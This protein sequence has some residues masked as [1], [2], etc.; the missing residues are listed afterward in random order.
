LAGDTAF[1]QAGL[2]HNLHVPFD[3]K[4]GQGRT[5]IT[6]SLRMGRRRQRRRSGRRDREQHGPTIDF[7]WH[8][9]REDFQFRRREPILA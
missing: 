9:A 3:R 7:A 1:D 8:A 6:S 2:K 4:L 5:E